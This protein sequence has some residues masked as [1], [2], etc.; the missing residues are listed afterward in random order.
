MHPLVRNPTML[1]CTLGPCAE[2]GGSCRRYFAWRHPRAHRRVNKLCI[3]DSL[4]S[5]AAAQGRCCAWRMLGG[6]CPGRPLQAYGLQLG[7]ATQ[8]SKSCCAHRGPVPP[9]P[10]RPDTAAAGRGGA[11][12]CRRLPSP[13]R[14][15]HPPAGQPL[16][17]Q[18][19]QARLES[20][21]RPAGLLLPLPG[22]RGGGEWRSAW[23]RSTQQRAVC[24]RCC[25]LM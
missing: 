8:I 5:G 9:P 23:A 3:L 6:C 19:H 12:A 10:R 14:G 7:A 11:V 21:G 17:G 25:A 22:L 1:C 20:G 4:G 18:R 15:H 13:Q 2:L 24:F 16:A